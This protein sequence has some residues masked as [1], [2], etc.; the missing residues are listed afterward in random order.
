M[1][2]LRMAL[3]LSFNF[4]RCKRNVFQMFVLSLVF[5]RKDTAD[6]TV[7]GNSVWYNSDIQAMQEYNRQAVEARCVNTFVSFESHL[8]R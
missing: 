1:A 2:L 4:C 7:G 5:K 8:Y 3:F 6:G